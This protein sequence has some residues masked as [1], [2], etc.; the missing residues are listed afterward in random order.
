ME[1]GELVKRLRERK[2]VAPTYSG[3]VVRSSGP[4]TPPIS[5]SH[6][7]EYPTALVNPDGPEAADAL[8][9]AQAR[10]KEQAD[11]TEQR[12]WSIVDQNGLSGLPSDMWDA[13]DRL[14]QRDAR[15]TALVH[16]LGENAAKAA[17]EYADGMEAMRAELAGARDAALGTIESIKC[18]NAGNFES[19]GDYWRGY[20]QA[21][22]DCHAALKAAQP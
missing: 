10:I 2:K 21:C 14:V 4:T 11:A 8:E 6:A 15:L 16:Q 20:D 3:R 7:V 13:L 9:A 17:R 12:F 1:H 22:L 5:A 19:T 18:A